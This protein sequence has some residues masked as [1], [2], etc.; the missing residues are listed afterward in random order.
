[1]LDLAI[2]GGVL[3]TDAGQ[4]PADLGIEQD[5]IAIIAQPGALPAARREIVAD[6][7]LVMPGAIDIHFHVRAPGHPE[8]G[9]FITETQAAAAGGVTTV[10]EMPISVPCCARVEVFESRKALG[11][12]ESYV[13][14][15]LYGAPGLLDRDEVLGMAEA[16]ACGY[17][18]FTHALPKGREEEF[19][20][21][22]IDNAD[23]IYRALELVKET[24][25]LISCHAENERLI[26]LFEGRIKAT[27]RTDP[28]GFVASRPPVV[29]AMS[30]AELAVMC[31]A[32]GAHVHI[33]H[34]SCAAALRTLQGAQAAGLPMTGE[35][36]PHYLFFT[37]ADMDRHG[38]FAMIKPPLRTEADQAALWAG[39]LDGSLWAITT[40]HSPF[41]LAEKERGLANIWQ[42]AIGSPGVEAL[43][44]GVMTEALDGRFSLEMAVRLI[45]SQPARLFDLFPERGTLQVGSMADVVIYD[46]RPVDVVDSSR[47]LTKAKVIERLYNGRRQRGVVRTTI[48][49]GTIVFD[50]GQIVAE[51]GTGRFVRPG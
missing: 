50:G 3:L 45:S 34:V 16:G 9:T 42:G 33:A 38:P 10:L 12:K 35:T 40:D 43:L 17:K 6:G 25:R 14:F 21:L 28:A 48:V 1:M 26:R 8:R 44:P 29:E 7:C 46:P 36:C 20:G 23:E 51:P 22:C 47:W 13:N 41:T 24:G 30:V 5:R 37:A 11:Q 32:T 27:G 49:N 15:G 31:A 2:K 39:L 18:I 4:F 19:L